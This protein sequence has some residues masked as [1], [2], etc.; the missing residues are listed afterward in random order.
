MSTTETEPYISRSPGDPITADD[1][2][3]MQVAVRED[4][5]GKVATAKDEVKHEGVERADNADL[6]SE[7]SY[8]EWTS[9][10]D[11]RFAP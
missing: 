7:L 2:N 6:F 9:K 8:T 4:I 11:E 10:I 3:A 1:W 5:A